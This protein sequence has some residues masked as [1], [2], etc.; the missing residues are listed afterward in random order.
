MNLFQPLM[1]EKEVQTDDGEINESHLMNLINLVCSNQRWLNKRKKVNTVRSLLKKYCYTSMFSRFLLLLIKTLRTLALQSFALITSSSASS[2]TSSSSSSS[3][4]ISNELLI[5]GAGQMRTG[6]TSLKFALQLLFNQPCYH[7]YDVIY[8][9]QESHIKKWINIFNMHQKC[10]NID[11]ANWNDIFNECKFAVD[12]PTYA[13]SWISSCRATTASDMVMTKHITFTENIIYRLRGLKS[14]PIL[15]DKMYTKAF[16]S[17][18]D[19]MTD[20]ELKNAFIKWNQEIINYVP[21]DRLL[22]FDPND[23]WKPL[24]EFLNIPIPENVPFPHLNKRIDLR[25]SLLKY[26]FLAQFLNFSFI[27]SFLCYGLDWSS[28]LRYIEAYKDENRKDENIWPEH[29]SHL[30]TY[31]EL[32]YHGMS[33]E[34]SIY[35]DG[36]TTGKKCLFNGIHQRSVYCTSEY[37]LHDGFT[38]KRQRDIIDQH[39]GIFNSMK[40]GDK[41]YGSVEYSPNFYKINSSVPKV[42]FGVQST[43][44]EFN[45]DLTL[46]RKELRELDEWKPAPTLTETISSVKFSRK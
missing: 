20:E 16:G 26:R 3:L 19:Q 27:I 42:Q 6:T 2:S 35:T 25:N 44:Q 1:N 15:H 24:C 33:P 7:M 34:W 23:G 40:P 37:S 29:S 12:Y 8:K 31:P 30:R 5:I 21:K 14:L 41:S 11:K 22:I 9:Y 43:E 46:I 13:D 39:N 28:K 38:H 10:V 32:K 18:Y 17:N 36:Y 4:S 45:Q